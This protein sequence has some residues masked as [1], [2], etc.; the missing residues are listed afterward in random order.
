MSFDCELVEARLAL[1]LIGSDEMPKLAWDALEAGLDGRA[2][3][4]LAALEHPTFFE[5]DEVLRDAMKEMKLQH[6]EAL[7]AARRLTRS[8]ATE[9]LR[10]ST[11]PIRQVGQF[12]QLWIRAGYPSELAPYGNLEDEVSVAR[13]MGSSNDKIRTWV[14]ARLKEAAALPM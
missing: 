12:E 1:G 11:D 13:Q 9:I 2:I 4:R 5:V 7:D 3:R 10:T 14:I 6:I 8:I